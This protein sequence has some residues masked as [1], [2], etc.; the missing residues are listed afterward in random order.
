MCAQGGAEGRL[1]IVRIVTP[2]VAP[3]PAGTPNQACDAR[4]HAPAQP[5]VMLL[6]PV[7]NT[8][9][10]ARGSNVIPAPG[11]RFFARLFY[12]SMVLMDSS[13]AGNHS[14]RLRTRAM[15][16]LHLPFTHLRS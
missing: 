16:L 7:P 14:K 12:C 4:Q 5:R 10:C 6:P 9:D 15:V 11:G 1:Q 8:P 13:S 2:V 3:L